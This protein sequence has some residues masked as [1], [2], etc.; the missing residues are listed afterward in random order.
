MASGQPGHTDSIRGNMGKY[1][2]PGPDGALSYPAAQATRRQV[3]LLLADWLR[4]SSAL[5]SWLTSATSKAQLIVQVDACHQ[6][7]GAASASTPGS[8]A[9]PALPV[10]QCRHVGSQY[11]SK[12]SMGAA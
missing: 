12:S 6:R 10:D 8:P 7:L 3:K 5:R 1:L 4:S 9:T 11:H 2:L